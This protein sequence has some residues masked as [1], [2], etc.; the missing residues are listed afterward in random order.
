M[1]GLRILH[2]PL[3]IGGH[4]YQLSLA[5]R[6]LGL[7]SEVAVF[8]SQSYGYGTDVD[9]R[10]GVEVPVPLRMAR[11]ALFLRRALDRFDVF[12]FNYGQSL[13]QVRQL[14]RVVDEL[15]LLRRRGKTILVTYQGCDVRP[16]AECFCRRRS[17]AATSIYR[18]PAAAR[19]LRY[20]DRVYYLNPDHGRQLPGGTFLPY[21]NV[22]PR[23]FDPTPPSAHSAGELVV[24]H[25]P[26][27]R[28]VKGTRH[29]EQAVELL[30]G[31]GVPIR[32]EL[33]EGMTRAE[34]LARTAAAD[35]V[36]D[37]LLIGWYGG[38]AVE[39]M[40]MAKPVVCFIREEENPFGERLPIVRAT[41]ATLANRLRELAA[42][43][44]RLPNLG[45]AGRAFAEL[46]HDPRR[47]ARTV[48][49]GIAEVRRDVAP[50][51]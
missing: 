16:F 31:E 30:R 1:S 19:F 20:A 50:A 36:V 7:E 29:V 40:A 44:A 43:R 17:C 10:A 45:L 6:E 24:V 35:V 2:A 13:L 46:E 39:A 51:R 25:A 21:A 33:I 12:H 42:D 34:A 22:D 18:A 15:P 32:L 38:Y 37:Q 28:N 8:S 9:L 5:E 27:D 49:D 26:T 48:L 3:D 4:A 11:R 23:A 41:P 47:V 14:G